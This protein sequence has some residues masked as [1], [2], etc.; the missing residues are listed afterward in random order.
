MH[1]KLE[2][3][4][5][6]FSDFSTLGNANFCCSTPLFIMQDI[7]VLNLKFIVFYSLDYIDYGIF[8]FCYNISIHILSLERVPVDK[9]YVTNGFCSIVKQKPFVTSVLRS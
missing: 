4:V 7:C 6:T 9:R 2:Q 3:W 1:S 8:K 5:L